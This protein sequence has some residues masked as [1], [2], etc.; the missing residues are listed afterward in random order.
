M[1]VHVTN[2]TPGSDDPSLW[3]FAPA[4]TTDFSGTIGNALSNAL[5][6]SFGTICFGGAVRV[7]RS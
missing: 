7:E 1:Y 5:G 2:L 3:Y 4:G 6:P